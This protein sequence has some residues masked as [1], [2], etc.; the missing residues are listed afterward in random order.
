MRRTKPERR[1]IAPDVKYNSELLQ[2]FINRV[3]KKREKEHRPTSGL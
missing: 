3:M 2:H 1:K